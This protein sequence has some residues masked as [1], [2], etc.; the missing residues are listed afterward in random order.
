LDAL[1]VMIEDSAATLTQVSAWVHRLRARDEGLSLVLLDYLQL[2]LPE[3][4]AP[5][6]QDEVEAI[7][8]GLKRLAKEEDVAVV[9]LSQLSRAPET[10]NDKRPTLSDLRSSGALEQDADVALLLFREEMYRRTDENH[11]IAEAI[12]AK[13]R[14]GP[15]GVTKL[16]FAGEFAWFSDLAAGSYSQ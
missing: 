8:R 11:G 13:N 3:R 2:L 5:S 10:R 7:S 1:P 15:T 16:H 4:R 14:N 12:V 6:R 9:A